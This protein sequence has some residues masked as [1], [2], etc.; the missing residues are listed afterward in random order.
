MID[1]VDPASSECGSTVPVENS[2]D[3]GNSGPGLSG[4]NEALIR[5][6]L[7]GHVDD[8]PD[9]IPVRMLNEFTYCPRLGFL[10]WVDGEWSENLETM[11]GSFGHRRVDRPSTKHVAKPE[12]KTTEKATARDAELDPVAI[13]TRSLM[14]SA[15]TEGLLAKLDVLELEGIV[16]TPVDYKRGKVPN[17]PEGAYEPERVQLCAQGLI[18]RANGF[19]CD[20]GVLY[21]IASKK[22]VTIEFTEE[23]IDRNLCV[24]HSGLHELDSVVPDGVEVLEHRGPV[25]VQGL[26]VNC[27]LIRLVA[28]TGGAGWSIG[29]AWGGDLCQCVSKV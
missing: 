6:G 21:F 10:E 19:Q 8:L 22:R 18:L 9:M 23:L 3:E 20:R 29:S 5:P 11:E 16:A 14:L 26:R 2:S 17:I 13:H 15:P 4:H 25:R 28:D 7:S 12:D 24:V 1:Q 27:D